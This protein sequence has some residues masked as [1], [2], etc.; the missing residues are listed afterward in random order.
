MLLMLSHKAPLMGI[1]VSYPYLG[2]GLPKPLTGKHNMDLTK[3]GLGS[4]PVQVGLHLSL[5]GAY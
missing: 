4:H 3:H 5:D 1:L 2:H